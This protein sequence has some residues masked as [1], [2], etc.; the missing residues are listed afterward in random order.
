[1]SRPIILA[2]R[3]ALLFLALAAMGLG[4]VIALR[5]RTDGGARYVC[6]MHPEVVSQTPSTCPIC[7]M[8]LEAKDKDGA[9]TAGKASM[10]DEVEAVENVRK[11]NVI[12]F[13]R[14]RSLL[15]HTRELRG[16]AWLEDDGSISAVFY[17]DQVDVMAADE[18]GTFALTKSP[19]VAV[20][21]RR[22]PDAPETWDDSTSR[23]RFRPE[24]ASALHAGDVGWLEVARRPRDVLAVPASAILQSPE[25]P[26]VLAWTGV[27]YQFEKRPVEIAETF[28]KYGFAVVLSGLR[29]NERVVSRAAFF[30]DAERRMASR[31]SEGGPTTP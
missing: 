3:L 1:M 12:D 17:K 20:A 13:V 27:G 14:R 19:D 8:A 21:V 16:E 30:L 25:G 24:K 9:A 31:A 29:A 22:L 4:W 28:I 7:G 26:Y 11:H 6:P 15:P 18:P 5:D 23:I 2:F 10:S